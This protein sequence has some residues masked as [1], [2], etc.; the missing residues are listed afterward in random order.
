V[1]KARLSQSHFCGIRNGY[2]KQNIAIKIIS[3]GGLAPALGGA[4]FAQQSLIVNGS[5]E[6]GGH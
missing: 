5:F 6:S 4:V 2:L 3:T 1:S